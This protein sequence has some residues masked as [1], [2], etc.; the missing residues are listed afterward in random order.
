MS[1]GGTIVEL[2]AQITVLQDAKRAHE[3]CATHAEMLVSDALRA[4]ALAR[5]AE[6]YARQE[7][8][9]QR[10]IAAD[11]AAEIDILLEERAALPDQRGPAD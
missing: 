10:E 8:D 11:Y 7:L 4:Q 5:D 9:Q 3:A 2:D 1:N 6:L